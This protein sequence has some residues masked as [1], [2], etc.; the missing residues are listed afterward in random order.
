[1]AE[2]VG[3]LQLGG[4]GLV[5][6]HGGVRVQLERRDATVALVVV[7]TATMLVV[8]LAYALVDP[9]LKGRDA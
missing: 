7:T 2:V 6:H 5:H 8:D 9:R 3:E 4:G 1:M